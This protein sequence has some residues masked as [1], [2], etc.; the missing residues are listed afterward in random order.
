MPYNWEEGYREARGGGRSWGSGEP[1]GKLSWWGVDE[2]SSLELEVLF[3]NPVP[4]LQRP[5]K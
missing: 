5:V 1:G 2:V 4:Q 3:N